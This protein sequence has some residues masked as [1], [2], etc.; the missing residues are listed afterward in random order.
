MSRGYTLHRF[1]VS[2]I[3]INQSISPSLGISIRPRQDK[4]TPWR[5]LRGKRIRIRTL[6]RTIVIIND[7]GGGWEAFFL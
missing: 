6:K 4:F 2:S 7:E 3:P 1:V 5:L